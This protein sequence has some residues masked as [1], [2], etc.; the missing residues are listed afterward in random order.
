MYAGLISF[1]KT[2]VGAIN[3][4]ICV[5]VEWPEQK[6]ELVLVSRSVN[7][8]HD[9]GKQRQPWIKKN[10]YILEIDS[11]SPVRKIPIVF[12]LWEHTYLTF[13]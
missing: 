11:P 4:L 2:P 5:P 12:Q 10:I 8:L 3:A 1:A 6:M 7:V 9:D 13:L